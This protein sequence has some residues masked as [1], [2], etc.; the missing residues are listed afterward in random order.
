MEVALAS[1]LPT[2]SGGLGVLA[3]DMLRAA[4]D[5]RLPM[6]GVSLIHRKGYLDQDL[7]AAGNQTERPAPWIPDAWTTE[8][9]AR[10][11][12]RLED[13]EIWLRAFRYDVKG[14]HD[15]TIPVLLL[16]TDLPENRAEDRSL[17][18]V[19]YGGDARYR[20]MQEAVLGIG[21]V[22]M[23]RALGYGQLERFHMNEG[24]AAL[25]ALELVDETARQAGRTNIERADI[26]RK[27]R[28]IES[29]I[30]ESKE[31]VRTTATTVV[32]AITVVAET[33]SLIS[34]STMSAAPPGLPAP[35]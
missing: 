7:D 23:L 9:P 8:L 11:S 35:R 19:L 20:L 21:G 12:V 18:D 17:T 28:E 26:E 29:I 10:V 6:V 27:L 32:V 34:D 14:A 15:Y 31:Q 25:L 3:G 22:R 13:R 2:Y 4:A 16:D 1:Y 30:D 5:L 24:H 33:V